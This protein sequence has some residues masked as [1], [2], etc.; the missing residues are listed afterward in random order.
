MTRRRHRAGHLVAAAV[1][2]SSCAAPGP[3][4]D[5]QF[6]SVWMRSYYGLIR[7]ERI[8][9]PVASRVLA[10][11]SENAIRVIPQGANTG[12]VGA[13]TPDDSGGMLVLSLE[14]L[15]RRNRHG[16]AF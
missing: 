13:S 8:S 16:D 3:P 4:A 15:S 7:A 5:P 11:A 2:A 9:P 6:V 1:L 14:R 12:L 10:Y